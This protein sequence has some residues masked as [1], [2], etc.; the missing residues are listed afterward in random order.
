MNKTPLPSYLVM[1]CYGNEGVFLECA[2]A[3]LSLSRLYEP[4]ELAN[5]QI[6]LYTDKP[7]WFNRF[8]DSPLD[9]HF[10][11]LDQA[12]ISAWRGAINFV[13]RIKI[14]V[15]LDFTQDKTGNIIYTDTDVVFTHKI[16]NL[17]SDL[18][19]GAV[20]M[21]M[22]EGRIVDEGNPIFKKFNKFLHSA[23]APAPIKGQPLYNYY[24]WNAG[25]LGFNTTKRHLLK[26][27]LTF[28]DE[29]FPKFPKHII[30][31][32]AF[33][34]AFQQ[35]GNLKSA[36]PYVLHYWNMKEARIIFGSFFNHFS[37]CSWQ[38]LVK[39]S[40]MIQIYDLVLQ[41]IRFEYN[42]SFTEKLTNKHW[43]PE[44]YNWEELVKQF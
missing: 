41:K 35:E 44:P 20:A 32:F 24:M 5:V 29:Q 2:F 43:Q 11:Q 36:L 3:L 1:Q 15:L 9:L 17:W 18:S 19:A 22:M 37:N 27:V 26:E 6:W 14:E 4:A 7:E 13:H 25:L 23:N 40:G 38:D 39:F 33:S 31:Q 12:T 21:H 10:R 30:E 42:R 34:V 8:K 16:E 28:T